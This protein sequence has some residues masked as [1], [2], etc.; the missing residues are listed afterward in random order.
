MQP[1]AGKKASNDCQ[2]KTDD[3]NIFLFV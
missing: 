1:T 3:E 2:K